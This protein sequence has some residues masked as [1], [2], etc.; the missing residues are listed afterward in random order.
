MQYAAININFDSLGEAYGFPAGFE[1]PSFGK[2]ADRFLRIADKY[3][4]RYT[5]FVIGKDLESVKNRDAVKRWAREGHEIGNH[6]W[7]HRE[8][9][10]AL[11]G[12][13]LRKEVVLAHETISDTIGQPVKGFVS[14]AWSYSKNLMNVL[15]ELNYSYDASVFPSWLLYPVL[16]KFSI[17]RWRSGG[18]ARIWNRKDF[19][20]CLY[21][22]RN[23]TRFSSMVELPLPTNK[24]RLPCWHTLG[25]VFGLNF[26]YSILRS[27]LRNFEAFYYLVHPA[28]LMGPEDLSSGNHGIERMKFPLEKKIAFFEKALTMVRESGRTFVTMSELAKSVQR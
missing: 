6:S 22:P 21:F 12:E 1:D 7:S 15:L 25:F 9:L 4:F 24:L 3:Q 5:I 27:C 10:G 19:I 13:M 18:V 8:N 28:D 2:V 14:P 20:Q 11:P 26:Y 23:P 16:T 17:N